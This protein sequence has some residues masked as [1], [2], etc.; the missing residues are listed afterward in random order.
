MFVLTQRAGFGSRRR[1]G[2][3]L[4][5]FSFANTASASSTTNAQEYTF[6][7]QSIGVEPT[8]LN[9][10]YIAVAATAYDSDTAG[11]IAS[12]TVGGISASLVVR[13]TVPNIWRTGI[14]IAAVPTGTTADVVVD[15]G[16]SCDGAIIGVA[17]I[18]NPAVGGAAFATSQSVTPSSGVLTLSL[19]SPA[20]GGVIGVVGVRNNSAVSVAW[21]GIAE[22]LEADL[23]ALDPGSVASG[24][25]S[26]SPAVVTA[27]SSDSTPQEME[28]CAASWGP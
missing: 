23:S 11:N 10:R 2:V 19:N 15:F 22:N 25:V 26:G 24:L 4:D 27:T 21:A 12:V 8:G 1:G 20:N 28:G 18:L 13:P 6:S 9:V 3:A 7:S 17:R 16:I 14:F 5:P